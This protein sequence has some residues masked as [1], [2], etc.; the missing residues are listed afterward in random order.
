M[1]HA[2]IRGTFRS[3]SDSSIS[4]R[5]FV[6]GLAIL[7]GALVIAAAVTTGGMAQVRGATSMRWPPP[8]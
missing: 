4:D 5:G 6:R 7:A 3:M 8:P 1:A 2:R